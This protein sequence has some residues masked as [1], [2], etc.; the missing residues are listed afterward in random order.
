[1]AVLNLVTLALARAQGGKA[2][3]ALRADLGA[4]AVPVSLNER[5]HRVNKR[6]LETSRSE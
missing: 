2:V 6:M 4:A 3:R 1:M 5:I